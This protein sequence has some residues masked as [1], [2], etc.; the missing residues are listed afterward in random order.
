MFWPEVLP[1]EIGG[2]QAIR[3]HSRQITCASTIVHGGKLLRTQLTH[4]GFAAGEHGVKPRGS[5]SG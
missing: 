2:P 4:P 3:L 1:L 5:F